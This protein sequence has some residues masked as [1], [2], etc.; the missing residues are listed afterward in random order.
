MRRGTVAS[1]K[2]ASRLGCAWERARPSRSDA[3]CAVQGKWWD[4]T[5]GTPAVF[6]LTS[7]LSSAGVSH[8]QAF[9]PQPVFGHA[10]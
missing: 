1:P 5:G 6:V 2:Q 10:K 8:S 3:W 9:L 4:A 7:T